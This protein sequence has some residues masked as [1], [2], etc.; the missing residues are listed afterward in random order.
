MLNSAIIY[1][2]QINPKRGINDKFWR[3]DQI[4]NPNTLIAIQVL[5]R[6]ELDITLPVIK[7]EDFSSLP[8]KDYSVPIFIK[9][10]AVQRV[11]FCYNN[12]HK[13]CAK[14]HVVLETI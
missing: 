11:F 9:N 13:H 12:S 14:N 1:K 5:F 3:L 8:F 4:V 7:G 2:Q 6:P 10:F